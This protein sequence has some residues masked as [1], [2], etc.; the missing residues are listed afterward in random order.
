MYLEKILDNAYKTYKMYDND[1]RNTD[2]GEEIILQF[3]EDSLKYKTSKERFIFLFSIFLHLNSD[4]YIDINL[5]GERQPNDSSIFGYQEYNEEFNNKN[6]I[7]LCWLQDELLSYDFIEENEKISAIKSATIFHKVLQ[8]AFVNLQKM[9]GFIYD[10]T[11]PMKTVKV[12]YDDWADNFEFK[13]NTNEDIELYLRGHKEEYEVSALN[14]AY[15]VAL[16]K[17]LPMYNQYTIDSYER[18]KYDIHYHSQLEKINKYLRKILEEIEIKEIKRTKKDASNEDNPFKLKWMGE[19]TDLSDLF[20]ELIEKGW[21][22]QYSNRENAKASRAI[23]DLFDTT[24]CNKG[25]HQAL[26]FGQLMKTSM[27]EDLIDLTPK[28]TK[29]TKVTKIGNH[30]LEIRNNFKKI[31][32]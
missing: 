1:S 27:K 20:Q 15:L 17:Y 19:K 3:R 7:F 4:N 29:V 11:K 22:E 32:L 6:K 24:R 21:I 23:M 10:M 12:K 28:K 26:S 8:K 31:K 9:K 14:I 18:P 13:K 25:K 16:I 5:N 2:R 30:F